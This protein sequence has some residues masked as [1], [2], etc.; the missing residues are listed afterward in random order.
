MW[1][2]LFPLFLH[3][4]GM[5]SIDIASVF[6]LGTLGSIVGLSVGGFAGD[7]LG[8]K[9]VIVA[10]G[11]VTSLGVLL[12]G[13]T[14][15]LLAALGF[16]IVLFG[17]SL[18][19]GPTQ[20]L[21]IESS[22]KGLRG[23]AMSSPYFLPSLASIP[24]PFVGSIWSQQLGWSFVF[25]VGFIFL[26]FNVVGRLVFLRE[27]TLGI[28]SRPN[29]W[30]S[31]LPRLKR[32]AFLSPI[33]L[34]VFVYL[35]DAFS[36]GGVAPFLP[37]YFTQFLGASTQFFGALFSTYLLLVAIF[38]VVGGKLIDLVGPPL[39]MI[40]SFL[41]E[42]VAVLL[43]MF[44]RD[45]VIAGSLFVVWQAVDLLDI[46]APSVYIG[47]GV[48]PRGRATALSVFS[49]LMRIIKLPAP[50]AIALIF[51]ISPIL[52]LAFEAGISLTSVLILLVMLPRARLSPASA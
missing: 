33:G 52:I 25:F 35:L 14:S 40:I 43:I 4:T 26:V 20:A 17:S 48:G 34:V 15:A 32:V 12:L 41:A 8:R 30:R 46:N 16:S 19:T 1:L 28:R 13:A 10:S 18:A 23:S 9:L 29:P 7:A 45:F 21:L 38:S 6:A 2:P 50:I 51:E 42:G 3:Q 37:L 36:E 24:M 49:L 22:R 31:F 27:N 39:A 44:T 5:T 47:E 11:A